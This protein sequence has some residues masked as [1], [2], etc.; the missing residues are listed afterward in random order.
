MYYFNDADVKIFI[1]VLN[2]LNTQTLVFSSEPG[3]RKG[4]LEVQ[5]NTVMEERR[6]V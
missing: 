2:T 3:T 6:I 4:F 5:N 1:N